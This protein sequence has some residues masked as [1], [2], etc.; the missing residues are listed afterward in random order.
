MITGIACDLYLLQAILNNLISVSCPTHFVLQMPLRKSQGFFV[1]CFG[2]CGG[3]R[4][5]EGGGWFFVLD[6][7]FCFR[8]FWFGFFLLCTYIF[9]LSPH[10]IPYFVK[11]FICCIL[12]L[13]THTA[14]SEIEWESG[15]RGEDIIQFH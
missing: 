10:T 12:I 4:E 1:V 3:G 9:F 14:S 6:C 5:R 15:R 13:K 2:F 8:F 11:P 7:L